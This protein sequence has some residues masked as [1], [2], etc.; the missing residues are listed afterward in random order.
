MARR[1][2][3]N[4][5]RCRHCDTVIESR[6]RHDYVTC[7]CGRVSVDGGL[8]YLRRAASDLDRDDEEPSA[9]AD[10]YGVAVEAEDPSCRRSRR[11]PESLPSEL[12]G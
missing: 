4:A 9:W 8:V 2:I 11:G 7:P 6:H 10:E 5:V 1:L 3:R 12:C